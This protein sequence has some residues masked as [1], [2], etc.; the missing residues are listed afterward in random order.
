MENRILKGL[1]CGLSTH[2]ATLDGDK[3]K[4]SDDI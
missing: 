4:L 1:L 3:G 2:F